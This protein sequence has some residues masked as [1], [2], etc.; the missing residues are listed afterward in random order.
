MAAYNKVTPEITERLK[1]VVGEKRFSAGDAVN[2]DYAHDEMPI[3]GKCF[4]EAVCEAE[5][6]GEV[7]A[8]MKICLWWMESQGTILFSNYT[9]G[10]FPGRERRVQRGS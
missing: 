2:A 6:T 3:Y 7:S 10:G 1:A 8:I 4:P 9:P 5:S